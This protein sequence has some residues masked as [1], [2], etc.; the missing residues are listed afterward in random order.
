M[1]SSRCDPHSFLAVLLVVVGFL[2]PYSASAAARPLVV[3][4]RNG[5]PPI[6]TWDATRGSCVGFL[7]DL[8]QV[9]AL[10]AEITNYTV[11][12]FS[13]SYTSPFVV[14]HTTG[15]SQMDIG[16]SFAVISPDR[17]SVMDFSV[18]VMQSEWYLVL[19]GTK[20]GSQPMSFIDSLTRPT[21]LYIFGIIALGAVVTGFLMLVFEM[22]DQESELRTM[23]WWDRI[24]W[25]IH[26]GMEVLLTASG[27]DLRTPLAKVFRTIGASAGIFLLA[28]FG[29]LVT[30]Q[31]TTSSLNASPPSLSSARGARILVVT[32]SVMTSFLQSLTIGAIPVEV[33]DLELAAKQ[34]YNGELDVDGYATTTPLAFYLDSKYSPT[35]SFS[36]FSDPFTT[37]GTVNNHGITFSKALDAAIVGKLNVAIQSAKDDGTVADLN[38]KWV[39][40]PSSDTSNDIP[41][42]PAAFP[43][44]VACI[45]VFS[46]AVAFSVVSYVLHLIVARRASRNR[47]TVTSAVMVSSREDSVVIFRGKTYLLDETGVAVV[48]ALV[49]RSDELTQP[50]STVEL[51]MSPQGRPY[52]ECGACSE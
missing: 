26:A 49:K 13:G 50:N 17:L 11:A 40:L 25:A 10:R 32:G 9:V 4:C 35:S 31:M 22:F 2:E 15:R 47:R 5:Q 46:A 27:P 1:S 19:D 52:R 20:Y 51:S 18:S 42:P 36:A 6:N 38:S 24:M 3:G 34:W 43:V 37:S 28:I 21:V 29:G 30:S 45:V 16:L 41:L 7:W 39:P 14:N 8:W 33:A 44:R 12:N 48:Q 23:M